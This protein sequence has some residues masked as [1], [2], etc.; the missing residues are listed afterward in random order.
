[1]TL[2]LTGAVYE[3]PAPGLPFVVVLFD[4]DGEIRVTRAADSAAAGETVLMNIKQNFHELGLAE[5]I[6]PG[7]PAAVETGPDAGGEEN[8]SHSS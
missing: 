4:P 6:I 5:L 2:S 7:R 1:M 8:G 3:P